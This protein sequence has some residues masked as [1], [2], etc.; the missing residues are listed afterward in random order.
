MGPNKAVSSERGGA[1]PCCA[2]CSWWRGFSLVYLDTC[3]SVRALFQGQ[4]AV[5]RAAHSRD[6]SRD[7]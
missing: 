7:L 2:G 1:A 6:R 3:A 4:A 5:P